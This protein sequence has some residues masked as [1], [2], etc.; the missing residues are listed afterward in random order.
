M[1]EIRLKKIRSLLKQKISDIIVRNELKDP[2]INTL[3]CVTDVVVSK[4]TQY[5]KVY[6]SYYGESKTCE[7]IVKTLNHAAGYIQGLLGRRIYMRHT[8]KLT[9]YVD[10][11]IERGF[12]ILQKLKEITQ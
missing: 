3:V 2:R 9:F 5:A 4:D 12:K 1:G 8:P 6:I 10:N 7:T 11:S